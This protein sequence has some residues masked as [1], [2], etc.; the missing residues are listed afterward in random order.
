MNI[1]GKD[2]L[3]EFKESHPDASSQVDSWV[4]EVEEADWDT[5][6]SIKE[7]YA[8]ASILPGNQVVFNIR[9]N[10]YRLLVRV[11]YQSKVVLVKNVGTHD[12]YMEW[13]TIA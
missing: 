7:R 11:G 5:P 13:D 2:K 6:Q 12:E 10:R 9:G 3:N 8:K 4:A 1:I